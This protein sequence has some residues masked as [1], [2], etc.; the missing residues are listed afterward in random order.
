MF[1]QVKHVLNLGYI[2]QKVYFGYIGY[3]R[4]SKKLLGNRL[5]L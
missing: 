1:S 3:K 2:F 4:N 5:K